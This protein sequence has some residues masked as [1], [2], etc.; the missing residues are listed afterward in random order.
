MIGFGAAL[1]CWAPYAFAD[2]DR[3]VQPFVRAIGRAEIRRTA[4]IWRDRFVAR[5]IKRTMH[6]A[7]IAD[8]DQRVIVRPDHVMGIEFDYAVSADH[9]PVGATVIDQMAS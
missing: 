5:P 4:E 2:D 8:I 3:A 7:E 1:G 6:I 9:R